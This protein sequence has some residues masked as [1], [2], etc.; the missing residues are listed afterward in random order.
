MMIIVIPISLLLSLFCFYLLDISINIISLTGLILGIGLMIDN[1]IIITENIKQYSASYPLSRAAQLGADEVIRPLISS[2]LTTSS[3]FL[4]LILLSG[5]AGALF[6]DQAL[7]IT[8]SL[9][10]S[11]VVAYFVLP[12]LA[13]IFMKPIQKEDHTGE[14]THWH[15]RLIAQILRWRALI[16][17][18]FLL[19]IMAVYWTFTHIRTESFPQ[20]TRSA[21]VMSI[22]WNESISLEESETRARGLQKEI[23]LKLIENNMYFGEWQYLL[24]DEDQN[25]N[26]LELVLY[27]VEAP[28]AQDILMIEKKIKALYP[29]A[30]ISIAAL[31]NVFDRIFGQKNIDIYVR[32]QLYIYVF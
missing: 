8:I 14:P 11:L 26:E 5:L 9:T 24:S 29:S 20:I 18:I 28:E 21:Y 17:L 27:F 22:D 15:H 30:Y 16:W 13:P 23:D 10:S 3:V 4:P 12:V 31:E 2:A 19:L 32:I 1:S 7:S 25:I 6:Y